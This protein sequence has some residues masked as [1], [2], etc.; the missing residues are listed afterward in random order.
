MN[1]IKFDYSESTDDI[2]YKI[3]YPL[4]TKEFMFGNDYEMFA[5]NVASNFNLNKEQWEY[6]L[7]HWNK[8]EQIKYKVIK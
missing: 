5:F 4:Y 7:E 6:I 2:F 1:I 8:K 3:I